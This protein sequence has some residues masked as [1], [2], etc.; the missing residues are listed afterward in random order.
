MEKK[1]RADAGT[2]RVRRRIGDIQHATD[3]VQLLIYVPPDVR[4]GLKQEALD[5]RMSM[6]DI[7]VEALSA[8]VFVHKSG[9][10]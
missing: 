5:R 1:K 3:K 4:R 9:G 10:V 6:G 8:R 2:S 7:L